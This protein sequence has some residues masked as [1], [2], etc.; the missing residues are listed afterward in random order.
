M[1]AA[2]EPRQPYV[3]SATATCDQLHAV[4]GYVSREYGDYGYRIGIQCRGIFGVRCTDGSEFFLQCGRYGEGIMRVCW[5]GQD[6][7]L[8][9]PDIP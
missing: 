3:T 7:K 8:E 2:T 1:I 9:A 5:N 6:W 4:A